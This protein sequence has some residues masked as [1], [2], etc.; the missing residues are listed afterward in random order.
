[1]ENLKSR[2]ART[3]WILCT[4][5]RIHR[6]SSQTIQEKGCQIKGKRHFQID[7]QLLHC[8]YANTIHHP[9]QI[10]FDEEYGQI[11]LILLE[12]IINKLVKSIGVES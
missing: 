12:F 7:E 4:L 3:L 9:Q 5:P 10:K 6:K 1:M 11:S 8:N 2:E